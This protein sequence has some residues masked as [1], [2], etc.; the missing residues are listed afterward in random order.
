MFRRQFYPLINSL[1][2]HVDFGTNLGYDLLS[3]LE[4]RIKQLTRLLK[5]D[6]RPTSLLLPTCEGY[7]KSSPSEFAILYQLPLNADPIKRPRTLFSMFPANLNSPKRP[8][9][10]TILPTLEERYRLAKLLAEGM[11]VLHSISW[12]HKS[13]NSN[14]VV[15]FYNEDGFDISKPLMLGFGL[16]RSSERTAETVDFRHVASEFEIYQHPDLRADGHK[17]YE[18]RYDIYSLG[19]V[20]L[21]IGLWQSIY[22]FKQKDQDAQEFRRKVRKVCETHLAHLMGKSYQ[23]A[24]FSCIDDDEIWKESADYDDTATKVQEIFSWK[25]LRELGN[26]L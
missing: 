4:A 23:R 7:V 2:H 9:Q 24:V 26:C 19:L 15:F 6:S 17:R 3:I 13:F 5:E 11:L 20:L 12:V 25:V 21:E 22:Y 1:S 18:K 16:G 14:N 10:L 8:N